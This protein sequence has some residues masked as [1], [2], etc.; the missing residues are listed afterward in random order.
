MKAIKLIPDNFN[1]LDWNKVAPNPMQSWQWG[2]ARKEMGIEVIR[3]AEFNAN[4]VANVFQITF[5]K[6]P[7]T[8]FTIGYLPRSVIPSRAIIEQISKEAIKRKCIFVKME[9]YVMKHETRNMKHLSKMK[10]I[11]TDFNRFQQIATRSSHP[12]FPS[13]TQMLDLTPSED[14]LLKNMKPKTRYNIRLAQKHGV[15]VHEMTNEQGIDIFSKLYFDTCKRQ[16]YKGHTPNYHKIIFNHLKKDISHILIVYY[17]NEPL[18][19]YHLFLFNEILYYP[20]GGSSL[21]H[22]NV[23]AT[24]LLMWEA[25]R[26]GKKMGAKIFDL[27]G[28]LPPAYTDKDSWSGFTQFKQGYGTEYVEMLGSYDLILNKPLYYLYGI[29]DKLRKKII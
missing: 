8:S 5:H 28:S 16:N 29:T 27:W 1:V 10:L 19:A 12:L 3:I 18:A 4:N 23:M 7:H 9:P 25:I 14:D 15:V 6:I 22:K 2:E 20:Y 17:Q 11:L 13:W 26:F 21:K 24:N